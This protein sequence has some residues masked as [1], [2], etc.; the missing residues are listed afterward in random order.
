M[1][2]NQYM[3]VIA[4]PIEKSEDYI[5]LIPEQRTIVEVMIKKGIVAAYSLAADRTT[6][7]T[8]INAETEQEAIDLLS[9]FP[10]AK[11]M[12]NFNIHELA[13]HLSANL[14]LPVLSLN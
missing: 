2:M 1:T 4:L 9:K 6:L 5:S 13:F 3:I 10:L 12:K 14:T 8:V 11:H 7:W